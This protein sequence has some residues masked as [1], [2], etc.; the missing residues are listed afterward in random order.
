MNMEEQVMAKVFYTPVRNPEDV[1]YINAA[2][3]GELKIINNFVKK[4]TGRKLKDLRILE[5]NFREETL[6][7]FMKKEMREIALDDVKNLFEKIS[8]YM[9]GKA[10][11]KGRYWGLIATN[12]FIFIY[13][14]TPEAAVSFERGSI[15]EF[16][17]YLDDSTLT[18][19]II[20]LRSEVARLYFEKLSEEDL[21]RIQGEY[22]YGVFDKN[23]TKGMKKLIGE[24]PEYEFKGELRIRIKRTEKTDIVVETYLDD[25]ES[26]KST[27]DLNLDEEKA[28]INI[29]NAP[30][31][32]MWVDK[33]KYDV[34]TGKKRIDFEKLGIGEFIDRYKFYINGKVIKELKD[35][36]AVGDKML[37]KPDGKLQGKEETIF[38][39]GDHT[40]DYE[41]L[42]NGAFEA[43]R[44]NFNVG[45]V[46]LNEFNKSYD[47]IDIGNFKIFAKVK[48]EAKDIGKV[49]STIIEKIGENMALKK[50]VHYVGLLVLC[51]FL[52]SKEFKDKLYQIAKKALSDYYM[53]MPK[54]NIELK[55]MEKIGIEFKAGIRREGTGFFDKPE[56]FS[57]KL[58][59]SLKR[60][61]E[62]MIIFF[63]GINEDTRDF[64]PIP[65][66]RIRNEFHQEVSEYLSENA[67]VLLSETVPISEKEG[68]LIIVLQKR[69]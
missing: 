9:Y 21:A 38:I 40:D 22:V 13:H 59:E 31:T 44:N 4:I 49:F 30:V 35:E 62:D 1:K 55:E 10:K 33:I 53:N 20:R 41:G 23:N 6:R 14:F 34:K 57:K 25:L 43:I 42:V 58:L 52:K 45:F 66:D 50:T 24:E 7:G 8:E 29:E 65:L 47:I 3:E 15:E 39:L 17:K 67:N 36:V 16:I 11:E 60:K 68:I 26:I 51:R 56:K 54:R 63:I 48:E 64:S 5:P 46:E 28:T 37:D 61:R 12:D 2:N 27:I 32:E 19:F 69:S 18:K